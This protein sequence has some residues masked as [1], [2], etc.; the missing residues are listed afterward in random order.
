[1]VKILSVTPAV[2]DSIVRKF[3]F[4]K[5]AMNGENGTYFCVHLFE[6]QL[7]KIFLN[8]LRTTC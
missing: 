4:F 7:R 1:M 6:E 5:T 8:D 3:F 2:K